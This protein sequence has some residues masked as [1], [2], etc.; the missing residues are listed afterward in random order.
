MAMS[1]IQEITEEEMILAFI[2]AE[3]EAWPDR[4]QRSGLRPEDFGPDADTRDEG[5]NQRRRS[6][7][8]RAR[9]YGQ[10]QRLFTGLPDDMIWHRARVTVEELGSFRHL[11][12][13]TF[14]GRTNGSRLVRDGSKNVGSVQVGEELNKR[15]LDLSKAV[16]EGERHPSL[17][18]VAPD[19]ETTPESSKETNEPVPMF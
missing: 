3:A 9:G 10:N 11:N 4:Y 1:A 2:Q 16:S 14:I 18:A 19:L 6:A 17:I 8:A 15:I 5:Q 7:L 13:P 12:Y